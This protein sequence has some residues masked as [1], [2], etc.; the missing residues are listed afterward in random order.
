MLCLLCVIGA[1]ID[2]DDAPRLTLRLVT[3]TENRSLGEM[4]QR[5]TERENVAIDV[6]YQGSVD[7]MLELQQGAAAYD[8]VWRA[9]SIWLAMGDTEGVVRQTESIMRTPVVFGVKRPVAERLGWVGRDVTVAEILAAAESGQL[10][11]MMT[12]ATQSN[13]GAMAYQGYLYAFAGQPEVL[14][15]AMLDDPTVVERTKRI[16]NLVNRSAGASGFLRDLFLQ[17]YDAYDG[18]VNNESA[19]IT[20]NQQLT[21]EGREPLY[22][23]YPVDGLAIADWP[24]GYVD[25]GDAAKAEVFAKLQAY[26][27]SEDVQKELLAAGR[28]VGLGMSPVGAD[29]AVFNPDSGIDLNRVIDPIPLPPADVI[30][31]ALVLY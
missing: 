24:L 28:R 6:T 11:Y 27:L 21:A 30:Q 19:V 29:P 13:S 1:V 10:R 20:A 7:T 17:H 3:G 2:D 23:T 16:L 15:A 26:L 25:R 8:A 18:M 4:I 9:S 12:S 5:F 14:T 31:E 22:A